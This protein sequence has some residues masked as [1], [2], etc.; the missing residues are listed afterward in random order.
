MIF[1]D[2]YT[3]QLVS[4]YP[5]EVSSPFQIAR[6]IN[7]SNSKPVQWACKRIIDYGL[8][9]AALTILAPLLFLLAISIK[10][11]SPGPI[12]FKQARIGKN[13]R[14]FNILKFRSMYEDAESRLEKL[15]TNN[16]SSRVM[17]KMTND[18]RITPIGK[19]LRKY[20]IDELPQILNVLRGEMSLVGPRPPVLRELEFYQAWHYSRFDTLPGM[21]GL[22]Q[23]SG[24]SDISDFDQVAK[25][26]I[27]YIS[28]WNLFSDIKIILKT[29]PVVLSGKG[30]Y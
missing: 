16:E 15:L 28:N 18:P 29:I 27:E 14:S 4:A 17:F 30:A 26:D 12:L 25:M 2:F 5:P 7:F 24:R 6:N 1:S 22:W 9:A 13:G 10:M 8:G 23:V 3:Q 19:V 20:S 11:G 21:T